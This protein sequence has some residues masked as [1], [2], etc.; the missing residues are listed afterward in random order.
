[1]ASRL[2][3]TVNGL[4]HGVTAALDTPRLYVLHN[5][6]HLHGPRLAADSHSV[7]PDRRAR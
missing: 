6:L 1:M 3:I 7:V 5:E 2:K 4:V